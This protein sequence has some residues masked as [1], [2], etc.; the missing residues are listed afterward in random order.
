MKY[1][2]A[3]FSMMLG[4]ALLSAP[5]VA[6]GGGN[7]GGQQ[8]QQGQGQGQGQGG[9]PT[10]QHHMEKYGRM[11]EEVRK[12][13]TSKG[14]YLGEL[15]SKMQQHNLAD[16][17][18]RIAVCSKIFDSAIKMTPEAYQSNKTNLVH[19][20]IQQLGQK[21]ANAPAGK[22]SGGNH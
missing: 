10:E 2:K 5:A 18:N 11:M 9:D 21:P 17:N 12:A 20:L 8:G 6:K 15:R 16:I 3:L 14:Q 7:H 22:N 13:P 19:Q 4:A 1:G